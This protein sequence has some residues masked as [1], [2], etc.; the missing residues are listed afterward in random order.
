MGDNQKDAA[1]TAAGLAGGLA[2]LSALQRDFAVWNAAHFAPR[3]PEFFALELAGEAGEVANNEKKV[4]KGKAVPHE[5]L[6]DEAADV[7]I[8]VLN[9]ANARG[10]DLGAAVGKK[11][12]ILEER[13]RRE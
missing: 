12:G 9:Y 6:Q 7:L 2:H 13:Q 4:W 10:I 5:A 1:T 3:P 8:S 11:M